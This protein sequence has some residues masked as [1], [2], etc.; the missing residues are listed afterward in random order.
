MVKRLLYIFGVLFWLVGCTGEQIRFI[1]RTTG[2]FKVVRVFPIDLNNTD[3]HLFR[4]RLDEP[5]SS[6]GMSYDIELCVDSIPDVSLYYTHGWN[7]QTKIALDNYSREEKLEK[8][9]VTSTKCWFFDNSDGWHLT[10]GAFP[11]GTDSDKPLTIEF[12][13]MERDSAG[14]TF[15]AKKGK[16]DSLGR[17]STQI[18]E[19]HVAKDDS[20]ALRKFVNPRILFVIGDVY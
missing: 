3:K 2:L 6:R 12:Q 10:W 20:L 4:I 13:I 5:V 11:P 19:Y 16:T 8:I 17:I 14:W 18:L 15:L 7:I 9:G 1:S